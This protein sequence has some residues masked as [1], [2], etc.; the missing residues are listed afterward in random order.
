[1]NK[2]NG[3]IGDTVYMVF[4]GRIKEFKIVA[5]YDYEGRTIYDIGNGGAFDSRAVGASVF[6]TKEA[7]QKKV[8][9]GK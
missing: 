3:K 6:L 8:G 9:G 1:M 5:V 7:A 2:Y 4:S